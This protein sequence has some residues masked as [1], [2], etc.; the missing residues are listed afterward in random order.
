MFLTPCYSWF[1]AV[2]FEIGLK[3]YDWISGSASLAHSFFTPRDE[4]LR[5]IPT[6]NPE[7]L[8]GGVVYADGQFDD[9]RYNITLV[10]TF[11]EAGG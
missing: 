6:L 4:A 5:L 11:A 3:L 1:D 9:A 8:V 10:K 2:Y 7:R